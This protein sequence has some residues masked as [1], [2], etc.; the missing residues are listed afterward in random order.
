M[1]RSLRRGE[2]SGAGVRVDGG[3]PG[4]PEVAPGAFG[5]ARSD[6]DDVGFHPTKLRAPTFP[7]A[8]D[9]GFA[10]AESET[11]GGCRAK[12]LPAVTDVPTDQSRSDLRLLR[13]AR[14]QSLVWRG[15]MCGERHARE[16][17]RS[18]LPT[19]LDISTS[20]A[21]STRRAICEIVAP[22][23]LFLFPRPL[24][25]TAGRYPEELAHATETGYRPDA[26]QIARLHP[27]G[28]SHPDPHFLRI[29]IC[30]CFSRVGTLHVVV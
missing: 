7:V 27:D 17:A 5:R 20:V 21:P 3:R 29:T 26:P 1:A 19:G 6:S 4:A 13:K 18:E 15:S 10:G 30:G 9:H 16:G 25:G 11:G 2:G 28:R 24:T 12:T 23:V 8:P 22:G 14:S